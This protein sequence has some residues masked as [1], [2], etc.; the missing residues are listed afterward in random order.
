MDAI[1]G[2]LGSDVIYGGPGDDL[3]E[4]SS[5]WSDES[6]KDVLHGGPGR[7]LLGGGGA[8][9]CSTAGMATITLTEPQ[10]TCMELESESSGISSIA[11]KARTTTLLTSW[12]MWTAVAR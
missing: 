4:G 7:D 12:T 3:L 6:S 10:L 11:V 8:M 5:Y 9:T 2:G 1:F